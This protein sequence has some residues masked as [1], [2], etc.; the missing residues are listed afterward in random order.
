M[1]MTGNVCDYDEYVD[2][3]TVFREQQDYEHEWLNEWAAG[4]LL[5][6]MA[7]STVVHQ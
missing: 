4:W 6:C 5:P 7:I 2:V 3:D 1:A